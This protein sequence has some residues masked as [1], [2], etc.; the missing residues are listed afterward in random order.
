MTTHQTSS[1][2]SSPQAQPELKPQNPADK[3]PTLAPLVG[4]LEKERDALLKKSEPWRQKREELL[5]QIQPLE[6]RLREVDDKIK[7][8]ERPRLPQIQN[9]LGALAKAMGGRSMN[10]G[11][12][13]A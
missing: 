11:Q 1:P 2:K 12:A 6:N 3:F 8:I 4:E 5:K 7:E 9:E 10:Q 13:E